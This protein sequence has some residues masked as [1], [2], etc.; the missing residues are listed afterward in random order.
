MDVGLWMGMGKMCLSHLS[1]VLSL[2]SSRNQYKPDPDAT[3]SVTLT[4][5]LSLSITF[6]ALG[7]LDTRVR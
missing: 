7:A 5:S 2:T 4:L 6:T 3:L 1:Q